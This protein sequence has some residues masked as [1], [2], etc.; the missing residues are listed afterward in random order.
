MATITSAS[1]GWTDG[2]DVT[3]VIAAALA[4]LE[5]GDTFIL[6]HRYELT[7]G[8][9]TL[10]GGV[11]LDAVVGAGFDVMDPDRT[12]SNGYV[13]QL[14]GDGITIRNWTVTMPTAIDWTELAL[15]VNPQLNTHYNARIFL[16]GQDRQNFTLENCDIDFN[17]QHIVVFDNC[18]ALVFRRTRFRGAYWVSTFY[19]CHDVLHE[20]CLW[21][22]GPGE[23]IKTS[24]AGSTPTKGC[25]DFIIRHCLFRFLFRD[26]TDTTGGFLDSVIED[27]IFYRNSYGGVGGGVD[28]KCAH[29]GGQE[30][31]PAVVSSNVLIQRCRF[32][33]IRHAIVTAIGDPAPYEITLENEEYAIPNNIRVDACSFERTTS[34]AY[35]VQRALTKGGYD[36]EITN[37]TIKGTVTAPANLSPGVVS[38]PGS[39]WDED[40]TLPNTSLSGDTPTPQAAEDYEDIVPFTYGPQ[41]PEEPAVTGRALFTEPEKKGNPEPSRVLAFTVAGEPV[42]AEAVETGVWL[43]EGPVGPASVLVTD[44]NQFGQVSRRYDW[45]LKETPNLLPSFSGR[46]PVLEI[47]PFEGGGE[48]PPPGGDGENPGDVDPTPLAILYVA[49][50]TGSDSNDGSTEILAKQNIPS[51]PGAGTRVVVVEGE[52]F[53]TAQTIGTGGTLEN[54]VQ[55]YFDG[56]GDTEAGWD[57]G[58]DMD[59]TWTSEGTLNGATVWSYP[60]VPDET[61]PSDTTY[62]GAIRF[63]QD[64]EDGDRRCYYPAQWPPVERDSHS[65][66]VRGEWQAAPNSGFASTSVTIPAG[67]LRTTINA[68]HATEDLAIRTQIKLW[69][70]PNVTTDRRITSYDPDTGVITFT[71]AYSKQ[72]SNPNNYFALVGHPAFLVREGQ[73]IT[74]RT[75]GTSKIIVRPF[76]AIDPNEGAWQREG[77]ASHGLWIN[78]SHVRVRGGY[79]RRGYSNGNTNYASPLAIVQLGSGK[80]E[81][82]FCSGQRVEQWRQDGASTIRVTDVQDCLIEGVSLRETGDYGALCTRVVNMFIIDSVAQETGSTG[83]S[84]RFSNQGGC[85]A[86]DIIDMKSVHANL[87]SFYEGN[88]N[89]VFVGNRGWIKQEGTYNP[90]FV[91]HPLKNTLIVGNEIPVPISNAI[92]RWNPNGARARGDGADIM[93]NNSTFSA[94]NSIAH[95]QASGLG[96]LMA[97]NIGTINHA[98]LPDATLDYADDRFRWRESAM[99]GL[100][101]TA[102]VSATSVAVENGKGEGSDIASNNARSFDFASADDYVDIPLDMVDEIEAE[103]PWLIVFDRKRG[104]SSTTTMTDITVERH[105]RTAAGWST[106]SATFSLATSW[107][108]GSSLAFTP[109]GEVLE[110]FLRVRPGPS[111]TTTRRIGMIGRPRHYMDGLNRWAI[112]TGNG[113]WGNPSGQSANYLNSTQRAAIGEFTLVSGAL[114]GEAPGE[115]FDFTPAYDGEDLVEPRLLSSAAT[116]EITHPSLPDTTLEFDFVGAI[117]PR[118][119]LPPYDWK[120]LNWGGLR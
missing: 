80:H 47:V 111:W 113:Y 20:Y 102:G 9:Y 12:T 119:G 109:G 85:V 54:P 37:S 73:F 112:R 110:A 21:D 27:S 84:F 93:V 7:G 19:Q 78:A 2:Q 68:F 58:I 30:P 16:R 17:G 76:G 57:C 33:D 36:V 31:H 66:N 22:G 90:G 35:E 103:T 45:T 6:S 105:V 48:E 5:S 4:A 116:L 42:E 65:N 11:I 88:E 39:F 63:F 89:M 62:P 40:L 38:G 61:Y 32:I 100:I 28:L 46:G 8:P 87:V 29:D 99:S 104:T 120:T 26:G 108:T 74:D 107:G 50:E 59:G 81:R 60:W 34:G 67:D 64:D 82:V 115:R 96:G 3:S 91:S 71:P 98:G 79:W 56:S 117:D 24:V 44:T 95:K 118:T 43:V 51:A 69:A 97:N 13:F 114:V 72:S 83:F 92:Q 41:E 23:G 10:P 106:A 25:K 49:P 53:S 94:D 75:E 15:T 101:P 52:R 14:G 86:C 18:D 1:L 70:T 77:L 55:V